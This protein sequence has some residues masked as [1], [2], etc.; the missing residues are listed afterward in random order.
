V[1]SKVTLGQ[2]EKAIDYY[3]QALAIDREIGDRSGEG[4]DLGNL[5]E[6][7]IDKSLAKICG[8]R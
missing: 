2:I 8:N 7:L 5:A 1:R 6:A 4:I 3:E